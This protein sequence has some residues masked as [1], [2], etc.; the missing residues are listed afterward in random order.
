MNEKEK[1]IFSEEI[2]NYSLIIDELFKKVASDVKLLKKQID[3]KD[4]KIKDLEKL[5][6]LSVLKL[7]EQLSGINTKLIIN[8]NTSKNLIKGVKNEINTLK[9]STKSIQEIKNNVHNLSL[10]TKSIENKLIK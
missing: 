7:K 9:G 2:V 8:E 3:S 4:Q 6:N 1:K 10:K 5:L